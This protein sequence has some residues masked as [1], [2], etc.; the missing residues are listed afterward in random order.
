MADTGMRFGVMLHNQLD[1]FTP[2]VWEFVIDIPSRTGT[3]EF[4]QLTNGEITGEL[5]IGGG[6]G[7][8]GGTL[9]PRAFGGQSD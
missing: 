7:A 5:I 6:F 2:V 1:D 4:Q 8:S 3:G 9:D